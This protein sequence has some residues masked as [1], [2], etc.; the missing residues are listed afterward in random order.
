MRL[1]SAIG[2]LALASGANAQIPAL[3]SAVEPLVE[4]RVWGDAASRVLIVDVAWPSGPRPRFPRDDSSV[5][6]NRMVARVG[7]DGTALRP[8]EDDN[9]WANRC[10]REGCRLNYSVDVAKGI[11]SDRRGEGGFEEKQGIIMAP[12]MR[13][14]VRPEDRRA[15]GRLQLDFNGG[16]NFE[17][18]S[19]GIDGRVNH[20]DTDLVVMDGPHVV[21]GDFTHKNL[22]FLGAR[23]DV[24]IGKGARGVGDDD[25][26]R[27]VREG[28]QDVA[29]LL[30]RFPISRLQVI[31]G[32]GGPYAIGSA[33]T[34]GMG[35]ASIFVVVGERTGKAD[36]VRDWVMTH[37]ML[38]VAFPSMGVRQRWME[39]GLSTYMEP[40]LRARRGRY[41]PQRVWAEFVRAMPQGLP[42][43][44]DQGL[45]RTLTWGRRYWGGAMFWLHVD[46]EIRRRTEGARSL[47]DV[48]RAVFS[49][50]GNVASRWDVSRLALVAE[51][52]TGT[53]A[54]EDIYAAW[55]DHAV[56]PD[57]AALWAS[58]GVKSDKKSDQVTFDDLAPLAGIRKG[59]T[60]RASLPAVAASGFN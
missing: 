33:V 8:I 50:G 59:L 47:D 3:S 6:S 53:T 23:I 10:A 24:A 55:S 17:L 58:L 37:E 46:V 21:L 41:E 14:L 34:M 15:R 36:L 49:A 54:L 7:A 20:I 22:D 9:E 60:V 35:G 31:V 45:D 4:C 12:L 43:A 51:S 27:W 1:A 32:P 57:L 28:A 29:S 40:L 48:L 18:V 56:A 30:G 19:G 26:V 16:R 44:G 11:T 13:W 5:I 38:H 52:A 2:V 42:K 25:I 39:E